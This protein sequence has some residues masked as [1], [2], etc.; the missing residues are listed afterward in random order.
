MADKDTVTKKY[1]QDEE[2][3]AD[4]FNFLMYDGEQVI[5][6]ESLHPL[7]TTAIAMPYSNDNCEKPIQKYRDVLKMATAMEDGNAAYLLLGIENQSQVHYA[8]PV[9]NMLYDAIQYSNQVNSA[10]KSHRRAERTG[11]SQAEYLS[12]FY[13]SDKLLPVVTLVVYFGANEWD[14][15]RSVHD[16]MLIKDE[17]I[18]AYTPNYRI[19]LIAPEE[20]SDSEFSK[21]HTALS[22]VLKYI[23]YSRDKNKLSAVLNEDASFRTVSR[24]TADVINTV[25]GSNLKFKDGEEY[26]DMCKAIEDMRN[27]AVNEGVRT[28]NIATA[29]NLL[30]L[31]KLTYEEIASMTG[32]TLEEIQTLADGKDA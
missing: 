7:D 31:E 11:E 22:A 25:T 2:I 6:P 3:F 10:A 16:M 19:N 15:P 12:G 30:T 24:K 27:D 20:I 9:R 13:R 8:M 1:M 5:K 14:A 26:V 17:R 29:K 32:L 28:A 23:K 21:F 4:A 18:L